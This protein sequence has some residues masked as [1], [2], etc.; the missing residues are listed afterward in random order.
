MPNAVIYARYSSSSQTEQSIEGQLRDCYAFAERNQFTVIGEY[1]DRA[2][3]GR[4]D[5][6]PNF[7]RMIDDAA[8]K[9]FQVIIVWKLDRFARNRYDSAIYKHK[10]K[11][12]GVRVLSAMENLGDGDE[13]ILLEAFLEAS[14]EYYSLDLSKKTKRGLRESA[15]K[16][17]YITS[18]APY[19]YKIVDKRLVVDPYEAEMV[20][21]C[22]EQY[23]AGVQKKQIAA[24]LNQ[25]G[26]RTH[27]GKPF[28]AA[29]LQYIF[30]NQKY[31]GKM[32]HGEQEMNTGCEPIISV[33][34][35]DRVQKRV[36]MNR[37]APAAGK[38][39][40]KYQLQGKIFCG[41]CGSPICGESGYGRNGFYTYYACSRKKKLKSCSKRNEKKDFLEWYIVEQTLE[42]VLDPSRI[43]L[44]AKNVAA[45]YEEELG[46][47][48]IKEMEKQKASLERKMNKLIDS[49]SETDSKTV[50]KRLLS[51]AEALETQIADV[52]LDLS[53]LKI[54]M[55]IHF[56]EEQIAAWL[57]TFAK[58]DPMDFESRARVI[59]AFV[60]S[61][62]LYDDRIVIYYNIKGGSQVSFVEM[63]DDT[64]EPTNDN[65]NLEPVR[66]STRLGRLMGVE[67]TTF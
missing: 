58:V 63:L 42:Y 26:Y 11:K 43:K 57:R 27:T 9:Q 38:A 12:H 51:Q 53:R 22:Y 54:T 5:D 39:A 64:T 13:S 56:T 50:R 32:F 18:Q 25:K 23:A 14:A 17:L 67:P 8:R 44:I 10:L 19:G 31:I 15:L 66:I 4:T 48:Q 2:I 41:L 49:I 6:R 62:F 47:R 40:F 30:K 16:G 45:K 65:P 46:A 21:Y 35:F 24:D 3:T 33:E 60:N 34:L 20:R 7:Q 52:E 1:I 37:R 59:D 29:N 61:V 55:E 36:K 28:T